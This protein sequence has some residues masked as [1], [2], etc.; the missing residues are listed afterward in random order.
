MKT[1]SFIKR[2]KK[3]SLVFYISLNDSFR[4][5]L[6]ARDKDTLT[7]SA[8]V[9]EARAGWWREAKSEQSSLLDS[10]RQSQDGAVFCERLDV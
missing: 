8:S 1:T 4:D 7:L 2:E 3:I 10:R 9:T 5:S 6:C